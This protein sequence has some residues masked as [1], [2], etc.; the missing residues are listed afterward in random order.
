MGEFEHHSTMITN[1][2]R[3][4]RPHPGVRALAT[5]ARA[6]AV[7]AALA[8]AATQAAEQN[9]PG[10][11]RREVWLNIQGVTIAN[12][13]SDARYAGP[14]DITD[15]LGG[16]NP[17]NQPQTTPTDVNNYGARYTGFITPPT[18]G[19]YEFA[20]HSDDA[21][22]LFLS[23]NDQAPDTS[24]L[25]N[26]LVRE[27]GCCNAIADD[28]SGTNAG[29]RYA[30]RTL[31]GGQRYAFAAFVK[32]GG[33]GDYLN[34]RVRTADTGES[35]LDLDP[36]WLSVR[37][38]SAFS[39][40]LQPQST[41]ATQNR[42]V[43]LSASARPG[44]DAATAADSAVMEPI[45]TYQ[46]FRGTTAIP[47]ATNST[48]TTPL[49]TVADSGSTYH[50]VAT[51][52]VAATI[53][54]ANA[55]ITVTA[56]TVAPTIASAI[57]SANFVNVTVAFNE[58]MEAGPLGTASNYAISGTGGAVAVT[59]ATVLDD[60][61][62]RLTTA[63][64]P[65]DQQF[66]LTVSNL[67]DLAGNA[68]TANTRTFRSFVFRSGIATYERWENVTGAFNDATN[69]IST[70]RPEVS[71][72]VSSFTAPVGVAENYLGRLTAYFVPATTGDYVF[73]CASDDHGELFLS[74]DEDPANVKRIGVEPQWNDAGD[75]VALDRRNPDAPE[76]RSNTYQE[77]EWATGPGG[78]ITLTAGNKY[79]LSFI[80]QEGGGGDNGGATFT[81]GD[82]A[83]PADQAATALTGDRIGNFI[84]PFTLPPFLLTPATASIPDFTRGDTIT[85]SGA[86][87]E[88]TA[89][90][91]G[92]Q[93]YRN[94]RPI[95][96]ATNLT[97]TIN[98]AGIEDIGDYYVEAINANGRANTLPDDRLRLIM[99]GAFVVEAEDFNH[100]GGQSVAAASTQPVAASLYAGLDGLPGIDFHLV[101]QST[102]DPAANGNAY[103]NGYNDSNDPP[104]PVA[105][106]MAPEE[107]G[108]VDMALDNGDA[109]HRRRGDYTATTNYKIGWN[110]AGE[111][112]NYTRNFPPGQYNVVLGTSRD[113][114][115]ANRIIDTLELVTSGVTTTTQ[116]T[117]V[118][119]TINANGTGG[120]SSI[121]LLPYRAADGSLAVAT[122]G[123]NTT[124]RVRNSSGGEDHDLD[125]L[126]FYKIPEN[127]GLTVSAT[128]PG[129][130][131]SVTLTNINVD[132]TAKVITATV[133]EGTGAASSFLSVT[134]RVTITGF[135]YNPTTRVIS[136]SYQ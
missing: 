25:A 47:D 11:I 80:F 74:T 73:Y 23:T 24:V 108:N 135:T 18:S 98:N 105:Y 5:A 13:T 119:G 90:I 52:P 106:P 72:V 86:T 84:D 132:T 114:S 133:P 29:T 134:P 26:A 81:F 44:P 27:D 69:V 130:P 127:P 120:W 35:Y 67:K 56:D 96:N 109:N 51:D 57:S 31:V 117:T 40:V 113:V 16:F 71:T 115:D 45:V 17:L 19:T 55:T 91:T 49:L 39:W 85:L 2:T 112:Y 21:G 101:D 8:A 7:A 129:I 118:I 88:S 15:Y 92:Y 136:I 100:T 76:N 12:L 131:G 38:E 9:Y 95:A 122:L 125:Y 79:Y 3:L 43:T 61:T 59:G 70:R 116:T 22:A 60:R 89:P 65:G 128:V 6:V 46:W 37:A 30:R 121:D 28:N 83:A 62:V 99:K 4:P 58:G 87:F 63:R 126:L 107:F 48:Y 64:Q 97:L 124:V 54:S 1:S 20:I 123:A 42:S 110:G 53:T 41:T 78:A 68:L 111:W 32:E 82:A 33:G 104:N 75:W 77:T 93:W 34:I 10:L 103:R 94:K 102:T 50:V 66:T 36:S 14:P